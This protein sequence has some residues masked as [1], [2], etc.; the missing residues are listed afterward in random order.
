MSLIE[1]LQS[2]YLSQCDTRWEHSYGI[3]ISNLDNPGWS[4]KIDLLETCLESI[5]FTE[6]SYGVGEA[7]SDKW[8][9]LV[10]M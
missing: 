6:Y 7:S 1:E 5:P 3:E 4:L 10:K 8:P 2:W 9:R